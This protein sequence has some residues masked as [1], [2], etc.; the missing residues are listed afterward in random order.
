MVLTFTKRP[1]SPLHFESVKAR[2]EDVLYPGSDEEESADEDKREKKRLRIEILGRQYLEGKPLLIQTA[3]LRGPFEREWI[4]PWTSKAP[5]YVADDIRRFPEATLA[6][7]DHLPR[8]VDIGEDPSTVTRRS[9]FRAESA[10]RPDGLEHDA[11]LYTRP[12][13]QDGLLANGEKHTQP[14]N[15]QP[16]MIHDVDNR[17][18]HHWLKTD[19]PPSRT[20]FGGRAKSPTPTPVANSPTRATAPTSPID[21]KSL[22][23]TSTNQSHDLSKSGFTPIN[24]LSKIKEDKTPGR[25]VKPPA[26]RLDHNRTSQSDGPGLL[27]KERLLNTVDK[28]TRIGHEEAKKLSRKAVR[29]AEE[30]DGHIQ[31]RKLSQGTASRAYQTAVTP[32]RLAPYISEALLGEANASSA[33]LKAASKAPRPSPRI[34]PPSTNFPEF[35]YRHVTKCSST[36]SSREQALLVDAQEAFQL[37]PRSE[38][39]SSSGSSEFAAALEA[40]QAK[41]ASDASPYSSSPPAIGKNET[42]SVKKNTHAMRR[43]T[44]TSS[45]GPNIA[46][47]RRPSK[48]TS[49]SSV[50]NPSTSPTRSKRKERKAS[51]GSM[52]VAETSGMSSLR[53]SNNGKST[54]SSDILPEAQVIPDAQI[55]LARLTSVPSTDLLQTDRQSPILLSLDEGDSYLDLSTQAAA[56]KAQRRFKEDLSDLAESPKLSKT[57]ASSPHGGRIGE[58]G[59]TPEARTARRRGSGG[60]KTVKSEDSDEEEPM[61]TQAMVDA[62]SPFAITTVKKRPSPLPQRIS[63]GP[64][65]TKEN[66]PTPA[67]ALSPSYSML[68]AFDKKSLSMSTSPSPSPPKPSPPIPL[69]HPDTTSKPPSSFTSFSILPNGT[70]TE[71]SI[72]QDGQQPQEDFGISLP[73]DPFDTAFGTTNRNDNPTLDSAELT[74]AIEDA[75]SFL[76]DWDVENEARKEGSSSRKRSAGT[77]GI[78]SS[79]R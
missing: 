59:V 28:T 2:P 48:P 4:N 42:T 76:G 14:G 57:E 62:M 52:P 65:P 68:G 58:L 9:L 30:N 13:E 41:A 6:S 47:S 53:P 25:L 1:A 23:A 21:A 35:K 66:S 78:L 22:L 37:R 61:S 51:E 75:G 11:V 8:T 55:Q 44:L 26:R 39:L 43:F 79:S 38:S 64:S 60:H 32:S 17:D 46:E 10:L 45:G 77:R 54:R 34:V 16:D 27:V 73:I 29:R 20:N 12:L 3:G 50:D 18:Q 70:L 69:S 71:T 67:P 33:G 36:S 49:S 63:F 72:Y 5:N 31:A 24:R 74:A 7:V 15:K 19:R 40:A 56:L